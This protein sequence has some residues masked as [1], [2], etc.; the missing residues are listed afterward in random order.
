MSTYR[1]LISRSKEQQ[2]E[3]GRDLAVQDAILQG[4]AAVHQANARK[5][6]AEQQLAGAVRVPFK[7]GDYVE[8]VRNLKEAKE[9]L[10]DLQQMQSDL[11]L[12]P[13]TATP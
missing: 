6:A 9:D 1:E 13:S 7:P 11:G 3:A 8:A 10:A 12:F 4:M 2:D 5:V